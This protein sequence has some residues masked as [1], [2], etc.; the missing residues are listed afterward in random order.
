MAMRPKKKAAKSKLKSGGGGAKKKIEALFDALHT[1]ETELKEVK[2]RFDNFIDRL[3][4]VEKHVGV[5]AS[6]PTPAA[7]GGQS[8]QA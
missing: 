4:A 3:D 8:A 1:M 6:A 2:I 5:P 7:D